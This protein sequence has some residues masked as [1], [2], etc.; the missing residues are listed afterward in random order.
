MPKIHSIFCT[1][2]VW[3]NLIHF[4][5]VNHIGNVTAP[6]ICWAIIIRVM[7]ETFLSLLKN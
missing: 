1:V 4:G 3:L 2:K 6:S 5:E 7:L